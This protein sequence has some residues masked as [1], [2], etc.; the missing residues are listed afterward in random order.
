[1]MLLELRRYAIR[2]RTRI[3]FTLPQAGACM[4][5]EHGV[6]KLPALRS[7]PEFRLDSSLDEAD[8][9][10]LEPVEDSS[11][12]RKISRQELLALLGTTPKAEHGS[13]E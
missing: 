8:Q 11:R 7:V 10:V 4:V 9:F 1:M 3:R 13:E 2:S 6:L 12:P 5:D